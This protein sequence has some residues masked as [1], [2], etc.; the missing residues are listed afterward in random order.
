G[1]SMDGNLRWQL[2][3]CL[4]ARGAATM[5]ELDAELAADTTAEFRAAYCTAVAAFPGANHKQRLWRRIVEGTAL[6]NELL[7]ASIAG[8]TMSPAGALQ[9][10][11][12]PYFTAIDQV[13]AE[14]SLEI[15][16]RI[17]RGLY[18]AR[19]ELRPG[20]EPGDQPVL[21][22]T[23]A[24]LEQHPDAPTGLRRIVLE[25][26]DQLLRSLTAQAL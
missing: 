17:V 7:S 13:W 26:R 23:D 12:E 11:V 14:R 19:Q 22:R 3:Q 6:S 16:G 24:W 21:R 4:A 9:P 5:A 8:F 18:P 2:W 25:Q 15:A 20:M 10:F 1:L